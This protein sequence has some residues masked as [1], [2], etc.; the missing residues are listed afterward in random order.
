MSGPEGETSVK[1]GIYGG[2]FD[3]PH[4]GH[5]EAARGARLLLGLDKLLLIPDKLPPHKELAENSAP[6]EARLAMVR[7]MAD[8]LGS[9][10]EALDLE[11]RREGKSYTVDTLSDLREAY[12]EDELWLLMGTDMFLTL[13]TW[14][15]PQKICALAG[16]AGF[17]RTEADNGEMLEIQGRHLHDAYGARVTMVQ[18]PKIVDIS[19]RE[20]RQALVRG[21]GGRFLYPPVYGYL[22]MHGLYETQADL[23]HLDWPELR[24]CSYSMVKAK[25]IPHIQGTEETAVR[26]A[27]RWGADEHQ[28][29]TAAILHDCT[30][31]C[32]MEAHLAL[33]RE[34]QIALD[35]LEQ[36]A[37]KLLHAKS[38]AVI[39]RTVFG[40]SDPVY[41]AIYWHTTGKADM[42]L[43]E[44]VIYLAD[45]MEPTRDFEGVEELR[46]LTELD[47]DRALLRALEMSIEEMKARGNP[48]H[49]RTAEAYDWLKGRLAH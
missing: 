26:L 25:R 11:L 36:K 8:G 2:T 45:Y 22:L 23:K 28:A 1:I 44:K 31:Y 24:A 34:H 33:C 39:A 30:K 41:E 16:I 19:S 10:A 9:W 4:L 43:L 46:R 3:P 32:S 18:L 7:H 6:P 49:W 47:L 27:R 42:S 40:V 5:M 37:E 38:G 35:P 20:L 48:L 15:D 12:P 29:R 13:Q 17:A 21:D 14:K